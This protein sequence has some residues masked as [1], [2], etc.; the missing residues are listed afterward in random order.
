NRFASPTFAPNEEDML[1]ARARTS[2][3]NV[4]EIK[5]G[6]HKFSVV[7]VGGQRSERRKWIHCFDDV[8]AIIF[9]V[10]LSGYN[11]V[12]FEDTR[13]NRMHE[14][15]QLFEEVVRNPIFENTP[16]FV[17]LNKKD[18]FEQMMTEGVPLS[19][20]FPDY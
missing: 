12:L 7:D 5:D 10:A 13:I 20:C 8:K 14:G 3:I 18:L 15:L 11:Q 6:P 4:T 9:V 19:R 1:M 16:I 17:F 2:G